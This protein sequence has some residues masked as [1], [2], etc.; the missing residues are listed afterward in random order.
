MDDHQRSELARRLFRLQLARL[1]RGCPRSLLRHLEEEHGRRVALL[2][3]RQTARCVDVREECV[4]AHADGSALAA[5]PLAVAA[6]AAPRSIGVQ[7]VDVGD[8]LRPR[9]ILHKRVPLP[10]RPPA[11]VAVVMNGATVKARQYA[12]P[13]A[14]E[15]NAQDVAS[16]K[17]SA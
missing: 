17:P 16:W 2:S 9:K 1:R 11:F 5:W 12:W 8:P 15:F 13:A 3:G 6:P 14:L 4:G 10:P 7:V